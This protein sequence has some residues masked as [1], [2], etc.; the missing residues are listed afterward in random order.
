MPEVRILLINSLLYAQS[1][2]QEATEKTEK[3]VSG[4]CFLRYLLFNGLTLGTKIGRR[5]NE[6][7]RKS[8][9]GGCG[10]SSLPQGFPGGLAETLRRD[11]CRNRHFGVVR[12]F[13][14]HRLAG[15]GADFSE[16]AESGRQYSHRRSLRQSCLSFGE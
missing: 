3:R 12:R 8:A 5:E 10:G 13:D 16:R 15:G 6:A 9:L 7:I 1:N 14:R 11:S 4:L 2:E